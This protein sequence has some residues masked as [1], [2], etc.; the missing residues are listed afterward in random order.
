MR[1][2]LSSEDFLKLAGELWQN[3]PRV[4]Y[5]NP[6]AWIAFLE[7]WRKRRKENEISEASTCA[8]WGK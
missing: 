2:R 4:K 3:G 5:Q 7:H 8:T 6:N 1:K